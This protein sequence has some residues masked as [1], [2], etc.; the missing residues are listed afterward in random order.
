MPTLWAS[1][2]K[3][4]SHKRTYRNK[5]LCLICSEVVEG[6]VDTEREL[7]E[8]GTASQKDGADEKA[9]EARLVSGVQGFGGHGAWTFTVCATN[10]RQK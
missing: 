5:L 7:K 10:I 2:L 8:E 1:I 3:V 6:K 4:W 9:D